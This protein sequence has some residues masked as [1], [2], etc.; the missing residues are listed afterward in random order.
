[1][2]EIEK[3]SNLKGEE[4][5]EAKR[6]LADE[7]TA[8]L[9]GREVLTEIHETAKSLFE[10]G[11]SKISAVQLMKIEKSKLPIS[12]SDLFIFSGFCSSKGDFKR[13][14]TARCLSFNGNVVTD[15]EAGLLITSEHFSGDGALL[16]FGKK[17]HLKI[18]VDA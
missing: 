6:I 13:S 1:M 15:K 10:P 9:H 11:D 17:K 12:I 8:I 4:I 2:S 18:F 7:A 5:N 16:S 14:V 3:M